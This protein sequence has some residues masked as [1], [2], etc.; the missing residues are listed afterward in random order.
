MSKKHLVI[1]LLLTIAKS[2]ACSCEGTPTLEK[3]YAEADAIFIGTVISKK[4]ISV[5]YES[6]N[7]TQIEYKFRRTKVFKGKSLTEIIT[8]ITGNGKHD[9]GYRFEMNKKYIVYAHIQNQYFD[10][11]DKVSPFLSTNV[12]RRTTIYNPLEVKRLDKLGK[13]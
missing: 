3:S 9:C 1:F 10:G 6:V 4:V 8:I 7:T 5:K 2:F 13:K 11:G 12:C